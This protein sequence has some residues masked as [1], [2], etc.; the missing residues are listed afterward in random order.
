[1]S[2]LGSAVQKSSGPETPPFDVVPFDRLLGCKPAQCV[3]TRSEFFAPAEGL[4]PAGF[5]SK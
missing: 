3:Y 4:E 2:L 1:M 5:S